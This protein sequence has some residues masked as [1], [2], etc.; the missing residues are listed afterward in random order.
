MLGDNNNNNFKK[1]ILMLT[2]KYL[3]PRLT[4]FKRDNYREPW[5]E[6]IF[7]RIPL[8]LGTVLLTIFMCKK[9]QPIYTEFSFD[10]VKKPY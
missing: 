6:N 10:Y 5:N 7:V 2:K 9:D 1:T 8:C 3:R 4:I